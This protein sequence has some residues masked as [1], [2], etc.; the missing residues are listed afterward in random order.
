MPSFGD[1]VHK[2]NN[3]VFC[4]N[5]GRQAAEASLGEVYCYLANKRGK[6]ERFVQN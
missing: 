4:Q 2:M 6:D 5:T 3:Y 1:K